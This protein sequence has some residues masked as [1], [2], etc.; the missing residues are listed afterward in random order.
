MLIAPLMTPV[1]AMTEAVAII[2]VRRS[3][4]SLALTAVGFS[5]DKN[6]FLLEDLL[7]SPNRDI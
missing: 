7:P 3:L 1:I 6:I 2:A 5:F 4:H